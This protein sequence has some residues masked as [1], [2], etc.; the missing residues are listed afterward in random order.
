MSDNVLLFLLNPLEK[1][2]DV[3]ICIIRKLCKKNLLSSKIIVDLCVGPVTFA[4][5]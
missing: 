1:K 3:Y 4:Q 2:D 5:G